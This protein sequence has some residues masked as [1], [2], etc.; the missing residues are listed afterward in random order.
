MVTRKSRRPKIK[1]SLQKRRAVLECCRCN[2]SLLPYHWGYLWLNRCYLRGRWWL[3]LCCHLCELLTSCQHLLVLPR[4]LEHR[5]PLLLHDGR[6]GLGRKPLLLWLSLPQRNALRQR[7][8]RLLE[9]LGLSVD[10]HTPCSDTTVTTPTLG[11]LAPT[12]NPNIGTAAHGSGDS[13]GL[14]DW[15]NKIC[16]RDK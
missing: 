11:S 9:L 1:K 2:W 6:W 5:S 8:P 12:K 14:T 13:E 7:V 10:R 3:L 4:T 15:S 16:N